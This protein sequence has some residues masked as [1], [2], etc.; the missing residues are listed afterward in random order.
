MK[1]SI[2]CLVL[3]SL[4]IFPTLV[5]AKG[6]DK[7]TICHYPPDNPS[8][9]HTIRVSANALQSHLSHGDEEGECPARCID[10]SD[11]DDGL[12]CTI[13][14]CSAI[15][16]C[17][18]PPIDC[19]DSNECTEDSCNEDID[20]CQY[21]PLYGETCDDGNEC[22][23][24]DLCQPE[25]G[26]D[27]MCMGTVIEGCCFADSDCDD[28]DECTDDICGPED[29]CANIPIEDPEHHCNTNTVFLTNNGYTGNLQQAAFNLTGQSCTGVACG[30][31]ICSY[32]AASA[33]LQ[34]SYIAWLATSE[35]DPATTGVELD[36]TPKAR[37]LESAQ[38]YVRTDGFRIA[39]NW[40]DLTDGTLQNNLVVDQNGDC[41]NSDADCR[42]GGPDTG[43]VINDCIPYSSVRVWTNVSPTGG[44]DS[45]DWDCTSWT[46]GMSDEYYYPFASGGEAYLP[47]GDPTYVD[48][49]TDCGYIECGGDGHLYCFEQ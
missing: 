48:C 11:C 40:V 9:F 46:T 44:L 16:G 34:G 39:D 23:E 20:A 5:F 6:P 26:D 2:A 21:Q 15:G 35:D 25:S 18:H 47:P 49:W 38:P 14:D 10:A 33:G 27:V 13:N 28:G 3:V 45:E 8:N 43:C 37:L 41:V 4:F 32:L 1:K 36:D 12:F 30:D 17:D 19:D 22:T 29:G 42:P 24:N 7:V 31:I